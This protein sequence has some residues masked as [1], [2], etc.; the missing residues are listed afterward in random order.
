MLVIKMHYCLPFHKAVIVCLIAVTFGINLLVGLIPLMNSFSQDDTNGDGVVDELDTATTTTDTTTTATSSTDEIQMDTNGD[1]VV[2]ELDDPLAS[3]TSS[4][5]EIQMDT[6]G[7]GVVDEL[8]DPLASATS[9][10]DEIQMDTNGDGVVDELDTA[11]TEA[12]TTTGDETAT[13]DE[14]T[15][16]TLENFL[17]TENQ[18]TTE[19][20]SQTEK[21]KNF[22]EL[23]C[24][25]ESTDVGETTTTA[26]GVEGAEEISTPEDDVSSE[27]VETDE[28]GVSIADIC[29]DNIDNDADGQMDD[30]DPEGC[31]LESKIYDFKELTKLIHKI[32]DK[33]NDLKE[34][35]VAS[36]LISLE[37]DI[38]FANAINEFSNKLYR[39]GLDSA[40]HSETMSIP[41]KI[42]LESL[43][44]WI[45]D[46]GDQWGEGILDSNDLDLS[47]PCYVTVP[48]GQNKCN[49]YVAEVIFLATGITFPVIESEEQP[50]KYFPY[51]AKDW[52]DIKKTIPHF[53]VVNNP[54][55]GDT[56]SNGSHT[57][58][59]LGEHNGIKL[60]ISARDD[61]DGVYGLDSVQHKH[62]IQI[63]Q[64]PEGD[65]YRTFAP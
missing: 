62:G 37:K 63:K 40:S 41:L 26:T 43:R 53:V 6:N 61:G 4:T 29:G 59:Y 9:S 60:Y 35:V 51:R 2:D 31:V 28:G 27:N 11:T 57:G 17:P 23:D 5:D 1:G 52:G 22:V 32:S 46:P 36:E 47:A 20:A 39:Q 55:M 3:A 14:T 48:A 21:C 54:R 50:G 45:E 15:T 58:I 34:A 10:T 42:T 18:V 12:D 19:E 8:D 24:G 13:G 16:D 38:E 33:L 64:L 30:L 65:V 25:A 49:G 7:D 44:L 56:W